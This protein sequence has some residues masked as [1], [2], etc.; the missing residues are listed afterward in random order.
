M[1]SQIN[2]L[3]NLIKNTTN[4][5]ALS[6]KLGKQE[7]SYLIKDESGVSDKSV[8]EFIKLMTPSEDDTRDTLEDLGLKHLIS[9]K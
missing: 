1:P 3:V 4:K 6:K 5:D 7:L 8:S 9:D 2:E